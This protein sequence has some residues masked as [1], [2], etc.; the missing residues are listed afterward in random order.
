MKIVDRE[1]KKMWAESYEAAKDRP[2][3][4]AWCYHCDIG[5]TVYPDDVYRPIGN[6]RAKVDCPICRQR[7]S[8]LPYTWRYRI[9]HIVASASELTTIVG[10]ILGVTVF[11]AATSV[12]VALLQNYL[13]IGLLTTLIPF[14]I[15]AIVYR[16]WEPSDWPKDE[17]GDFDRKRVLRALRV[18]DDD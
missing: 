18:G 1:L 12:H 6:F 7:C 3:S 15:V 4:L 2:K 9:R 5:F 17:H 11:M 10:T 8:V 14:V 16:Y 13:W